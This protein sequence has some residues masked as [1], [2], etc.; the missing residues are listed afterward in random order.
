MRYKRHNRILGVGLA[1]G[2]GLAAATA[3][4]AAT[5]HA[6]LGDLGQGLCPMVGQ[7]GSKLASAASNAV[8]VASEITGKQG[9]APEMAGPI[10]GMALE[11][12]CPA[13]LASV[14]RGHLPNIPFIM[15]DRPDV[16]GIFGGSGD[17]PGVPGGLPA[18]IGGT[19]ALPV[20]AP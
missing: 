8:S 5:A 18:L 10:G 6:D 16:P 19:G 17:L 20:P 7:G 4:W 13:A 3:I 15:T 1:V 11:G 9:P 2:A 12:F 14:G